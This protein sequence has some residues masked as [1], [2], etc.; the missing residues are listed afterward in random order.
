MSKTTLALEVLSGPLDGHTIWI[1]NEA[2]WT[3]AEGSLLSFPWDSEL[4]VPQARFYIEAESWWLEA[5]PETAHGTYCANRVGRIEEKIQ[6]Q[7]GDLL[8]ANETWLLVSQ[9]S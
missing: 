3:Q 7:A 4:N 8:K 1:T 2:L 6:L 5:M 9:M